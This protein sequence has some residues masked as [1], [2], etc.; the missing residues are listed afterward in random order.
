MTTDEA[1]LRLSES[2]ADAVAT[3]LR[4]FAV[5]HVDRGVAVV[6]PAGQSPFEGIPI[7]SVSARVNYIDGITGGNVFIMSLAGAYRLA[8]AMAGVEATAVA[9]AGPGA[10]E[11]RP[12]IGELEL[13][14]V[15]EAALQ[16]MAEA[17]A[18][19]SVVLGHEVEVSPP[20]TRVL[21]SVEAAESS[22]ERI[23]YA[24]VVSFTVLG[25]P[26][27][28]IQLVPNAFVVRMTRAFVDLSAESVGAERHGKDALF[29]PELLRNVPVRVSVELGRAR[30]SLARAV[31]LPAGAV[32]ELD[33]V[34]D[35]PVDLLVN[36]RRYAEGRLVLLEGNEWALQIDRMLNER[37]DRSPEQED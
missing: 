11:A 13:S 25:E 24:T 10:D 6:V 1:L 21:D 30:M 37:A 17:A 5:D 28:L 20:E 31:G 4:T 7:P 14:A 12:E 34:A 19:M 9:S 2:T 16:M 8:A 23:P 15:G 3:V 35:E 36:G 27:R 22:E 32:V 26:C 29:S 33:R 18:A